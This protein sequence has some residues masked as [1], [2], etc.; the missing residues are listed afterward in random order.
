[1][2]GPLMKP[3]LT[4]LFLS[5]LVMGCFARG[6]KSDAKADS[7]LSQAPIPAAPFDVNPG[8]PQQGFQQDI[9]GT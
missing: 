2:I 3:L 5:L 9:S 7:Q 4:L 8:E 1:M 6:A